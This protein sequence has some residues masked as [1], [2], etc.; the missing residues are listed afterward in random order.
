MSGYKFPSNKQVNDS[1]VNSQAA[2]PQV[3]VS[4]D[5]LS[6][7]LQVGDKTS[8]KNITSRLHDCPVKLVTRLELPSKRFAI[9]PYV[10][11]EIDRPNSDKRRVTALSPLS[12]DLKLI[13]GLLHIPN[14]WRC[15][16]FVGS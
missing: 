7:T 11:G 1:Q 9:W 3:I 15:G 14:T 16:G 12:T 4:L 6:V 8:G 13:A 5:K 10:C 2:T